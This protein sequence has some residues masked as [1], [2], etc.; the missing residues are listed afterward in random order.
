MELIGLDSAKVFFCPNPNFIESWLEVR[1]GAGYSAL[2]CSKQP[3]QPSLLGWVWC[4]LATHKLRRYS[5]KLFW[6]RSKILVLGH[7]TLTQIL[8]CPITGFI[9]PSQLSNSW[10]ILQDLIQRQ[11]NI[12]YNRSNNIGDNNNN[13][14]NN[15]NNHWRLGYRV[16]I[17]INRNWLSLFLEIL[18][19]KLSSEAQSWYVHNNWKWLI[20][21]LQ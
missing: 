17:L 14:N 19:T 7:S 5:V 11:C 1:F 6:L 21:W 18:S 2:K 10:C 15:D 9:F 3:K 12:D 8:K 16:W 4:N 20:L 13:S